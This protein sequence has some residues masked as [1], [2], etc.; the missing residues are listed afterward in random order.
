MTGLIE[1]AAQLRGY[2]SADPGNAM[3]ACDVIDALFAAGS[4]VEADELITQLPNETQAAIGIRFRRARCALI[5]GRYAEAADVLRALIADGQENVALWHDLAFSQLCLRQ[6]ADAAGTLD[7]AQARF[8]TNAE[9]AIV[10]ARV[11]MMDGNFEAANAAL[12]QAVELAPDHATAR[13]LRALAQLDSG[14][15]DEAYATAEA[16]LAQYPDQHEA[17]LVAGT[18]ALWRQDLDRADAYHQRALGRHPNSGRALSGYGQLK[19]LRNELPAAREQLAHAV[20]AM[21][22][23]IGTWHALAWTDLLLGDIDGAE[24]SYQQGFD[25]DRNFADSH[26]GLALIHALR[27]RTD[28]AD[29]AIKRALRLNPECATALYAKTLLLS[30]SGRSDEADKLLEGLMA[31]SPVPLNTNIR[32]FATNL[33][34]RFTSK[35]G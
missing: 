22:D 26:G 34:S 1:R 3:L 18:V 17:L 35:A 24:A 32:D 9:L 14:S 7:E 10:R 30:D 31:N 4:H 16:C 6:T 2:L 28:E 8:G 33:R 11:A 15:P 29:L 5:R 21:P 20:I 25:L 27:G 13:G 12:D 23:H 19:M